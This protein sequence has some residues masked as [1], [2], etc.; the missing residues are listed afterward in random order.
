MRWTDFEGN[1]RESAVSFDP[2]CRDETIADL[3]SLGMT[4]IEPYLYDPLNDKEIPQ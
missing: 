4:D 3:K 1:R 2:T